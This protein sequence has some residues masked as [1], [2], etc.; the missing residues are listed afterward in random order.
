ME[1]NGKVSRHFWLSQG[2]ARTLG[3]DLNGALRDGRLARNDYADAIGQCCTC[4]HVRTC[5]GWLARQGAGA[6]AAPG[7]CALAPLLE[8][9]KQLD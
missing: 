8:R 5:M 6:E 4:P 7:Y 3:V 1:E 9:V 2:M